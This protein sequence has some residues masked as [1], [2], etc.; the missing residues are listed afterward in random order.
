M[1]SATF[2]RAEAALTASS[3]AH[4]ERFMEPLQLVAVLFVTRGADPDK[5]GSAVSAHLC[6]ELG[7]RFCLS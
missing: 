3:Q 7:R 1:P 2:E 4:M 6:R 5:E